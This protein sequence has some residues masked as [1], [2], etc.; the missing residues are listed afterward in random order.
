[1]SYQKNLK[2]EKIDRAKNTRCSGCALTT[3]SGLPGY[4]TVT[5]KKRRRAIR[6]AIGLAMTPCY[7]SHRDLNGGDFSISIGGGDPTHEATSA[8][9]RPS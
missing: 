9:Q 6:V 5:T 8:W 1:M 3:S 7:Q 4:T 2:H